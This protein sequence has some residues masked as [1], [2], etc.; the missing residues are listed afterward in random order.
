MPQ[1][2]VLSKKVTLAE[3]VKKHQVV[4]FSGYLATTDT[5]G[6]E[7]AG[8]TMYDGNAGELAAIMCVGLITAP[9]DG[10][11]VLGDM[12]KVQAGVVVKATTKAEAFATVC[13]VPTVNSVELLL[14]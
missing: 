12:V 2:N 9:Q 8:V 5:V 3:D 6:K 4:S 13:E 1:H 10:T 11:L 7:P 14:K